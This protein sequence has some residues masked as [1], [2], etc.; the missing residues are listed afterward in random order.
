[1][2]EL[3]LEPVEVTAHGEPA[4]WFE[5][6]QQKFGAIPPVVGEIIIFAPLGILLG[7]LS[8]ILGRYLVV[9]VVLA[10][11]LLWAADQFHLVTLHMSEIKAFFGVHGI[12]S[13]GDWWRALLSWAQ[14][15]IVGCLALVA[16]FITGW[17]L[18]N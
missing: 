7:F 2:E 18:G 14:A 17:R 15:H 11:V 10:F 12:A 5:A 9:G 13:I 6:L 1:M 4:S 3:T 16:G 8:K